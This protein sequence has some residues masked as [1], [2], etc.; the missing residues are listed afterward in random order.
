MTVPIVELQSGDKVDRGT[1]VTVTAIFCDD[2]HGQV[3]AAFLRPGTNRAVVDPGFGNP[4]S[5]IR[6]L[7]NLTY[8]YAIDTTGFS[9]GK[10]TWH[11][12]SPDEGSKFDWFE[13]ND[14]PA[15][16]L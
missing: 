14:A 9:V 4:G 3:F 6:Q 1:P 10:V 5:R 8:T 11:I 13:I 12:W 15:Q 7:N 2:P 16:L